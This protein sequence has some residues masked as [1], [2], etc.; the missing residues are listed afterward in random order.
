M[1]DFV[2]TDGVSQ[3]Q[4]PYYHH[5]VSLEFLN[6]GLIEGHQLSPEHLLHPEPIH[7]LSEN[8]ISA[9]YLTKE[10][11]P[12]SPAIWVIDSRA[13][14]EDEFNQTINLTGF[15]NSFIHNQ[16][17]SVIAISKIY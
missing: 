8:K 1:S 4:T 11:S 17:G 15:S 3:K 5:P 10:R 2:L 7:I 16:D 14:L 9:F 12:F 13:L 6:R